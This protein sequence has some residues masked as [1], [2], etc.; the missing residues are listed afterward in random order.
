M[1]SYQMSALQKCLIP[2]L[3]LREAWL[4]SLAMISGQ[5]T[6]QRSAMLLGGGLDKENSDSTI[7]MVV[8][9]DNYKVPFVEQ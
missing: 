8:G 4:L 6:D 2:R 3:F 9:I 1:F 7:L 5:E